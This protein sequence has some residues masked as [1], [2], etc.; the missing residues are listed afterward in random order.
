MTN[1]KIKVKKFFY[2]YWFYNNFYVIMCIKN[3]HN[4]NFFKKFE[5]TTRKKSLNLGKKQKMEIKNKKTLPK[6]VE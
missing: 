5:K 3:T 1:R 4:I 2:F 6:T